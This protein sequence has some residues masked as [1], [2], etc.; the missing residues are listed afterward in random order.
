MIFLVSQ[1]LQN[2]GLNIYVC[3]NLQPL[4]SVLLHMFLMGF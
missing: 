2:L 3:G 1:N 4:V